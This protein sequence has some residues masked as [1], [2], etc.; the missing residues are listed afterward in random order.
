VD[1]SAAKLAT[2]ID[3]LT[4]RTGQ[5]VALIAE[6]EG[7]L[8]ARAYFAR[9]D[10]PPVS[11]VQTYAFIPLAGA[12]VVYHGRVSHVP[13]S[14]LPG[15]HSNLLRNDP[16][17]QDIERLLTSGKFTTHDAPTTAFRAI[18]GAAAACQVPALP[19]HRRAG[20]DAPPH[21]DPAFANWHCYSP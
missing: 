14:A 9:H 5:S 12:T 13:W 17:V 15:W 19:L 8:V 10:N 18:W 1:V 21:T 2:Q 7:T 11:G 4:A 16:V 20:W 3:W 6:S